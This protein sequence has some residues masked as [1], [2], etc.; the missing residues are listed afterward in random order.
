M[1]AA[2]TV[3][4]ILLSYNRPEMLREALASVV[5]QSYLNLRVIV[6][7]N[8]SPASDRIAEVVAGFS[9]VE[10]I[11]SPTNTGF[12]GGMNLG[13]RHAS[14]KYV[15]F[16][17]DDIVV[18]G[19]AVKLLVAHMEADPVTGLGGA[20]MLNRATG[21]IRC[22]GGEV[23]L[24]KRF[25]FQ[26]IGRH[27]LPTD[28][29]TAPYPVTYLPGAFILARRDLLDRI[30]GFWDKLFMYNDDVELCVRATRAGAGIV[31]VPAARVWHFDPPVRPDPVWLTALKVRNMLWLYIR[32]APIGVLIPF[33]A[34]YCLVG[35]IRGLVTNPRHALALVR[36]VV[37]TGIRLPT[38]LTWRWARP[39]RYVPSAN[40]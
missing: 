2:P 4:V 29:E 24:G 36:A 20:V 3:S 9:G 5:T 31:V 19:N 8:K 37:A 17:E 39:P 15:L 40:L 38:L 26:V 14:G 34:R 28:R 22:A 30:G 27:E 16:T 33:L 32:H 6:I 13:L 12:T 11:A 25:D 21:T 10:L 18:D 1:T 23:R 35:F 7:D